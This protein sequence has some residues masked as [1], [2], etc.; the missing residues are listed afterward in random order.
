MPLN[1][2]TKT[3]WNSRPDFLGLQNR[4]FI[5]IFSA[6]EK[7]NNSVHGLESTFYEEMLIELWQ[8]PSNVRSNLSDTRSI[9][10]SKRRSQWACMEHTQPQHSKNTKRRKKWVSA[11]MHVVLDRFEKLMHERILFILAL[12][13][14]NISEVL[15]MVYFSLLLFNV[16]IIDSYIVVNSGI[17]IIPLYSK[18]SVLALSITCLLSSSKWDRDLVCRGCW[19]LKFSFLSPFHGDGKLQINDFPAYFAFAC[20]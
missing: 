18:G 5:Y 2:R 16:P 14:S 10:T 13:L 15:K 8:V 11:G 7:V 12:L 1:G 20:I 17:Q 6:A 9:A 4:F 19:M 3:N